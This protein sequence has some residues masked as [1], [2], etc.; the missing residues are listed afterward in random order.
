MPLGA[1]RVARIAWWAGIVCVTLAPPAHAQFVTVGGGVLV[2]SRGADPVAE[3][4]AEAPPFAEARGHVT[5]SWTQES[6]KPTLI[7]A[8]ERPVLRVE[9][10]LV[11]LGGGVLWGEVNGYR[12]YRLMVSSTVVP[13]QIPR[14][15]FVL[16][17]STLPT[18]DFDWVLDLKVGVT[19]LF[20]R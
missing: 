5:A 3:V 9:Q 13:L 6:V 11:G 2:T 14:T 20:V 18:E 12:A 16:I 7:S 15:S 1:L 17:A 10:A 19:A 4:H 8:I